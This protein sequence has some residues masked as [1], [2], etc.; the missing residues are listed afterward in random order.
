MPIPGACAAIAALSVAGLATDRFCFEGF[1]PA[2]PAARRARLDG[3]K[4][5]QRTLV[6]YE[7]PHRIAETLA[8]LLAAFGSR[9]VAVAR[10]LTKLHET[11][12]HGDLAALAARAEIDP[13]LRRG[14]IVVVVDGAADAPGD[15]AAELDRLLRALLADLPVSRAVD[16]AVEIS[17]ARRNVA[18]KAA[19][20]LSGADGGTQDGA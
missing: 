3:L 13:D 8:D 2:K 16:I 1:L 6:F 5:E 14:E 10:E 12:Y 18:Y 4:G 15:G 9:R 7:A 11:V 19:L 20:R 17:G